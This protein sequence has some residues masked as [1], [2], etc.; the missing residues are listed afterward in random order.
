[1][2]K[3]D[4]GTLRR[5]CNRML[6]TTERAF[7]RVLV[8]NKVIYSRSASIAHFL[9]VLKAFSA[10]H[11]GRKVKSLTL[12]EECLKEHE[13]RSEWA[14]ED[15]EQRM[16]LDFTAQDQNIIANLNRDHANEAHI[17]TAFLTSGRYR[18]TL[19]SILAM[20]PNLRV[21]NIRKLQVSCVFASTYVTC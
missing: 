19:G 10:L 12:V 3:K 18:T 13:Y 4:I 6:E 8:E 5:T 20:C 7:T 9:A 16:G 21:L 1:M 15:F 14:W 11:L 2:D 17:D